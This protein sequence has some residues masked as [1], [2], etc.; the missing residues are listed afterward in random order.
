MIYKLACGASVFIGFGQCAAIICSQLPELK[1]GWHEQNLDWII[2]VT[3]ILSSAAAL[4][5]ISAKQLGSVGEGDIWDYSSVMMKNAVLHG[6]APYLVLNLFLYKALIKNIIHDTEW[7][8]E[9][10]ALACTSCFIGLCT[11]GL[12]IK[13][14]RCVGK[15]IGD[16]KAGVFVL[17]NGICL[18]ISITAPEIAIRFCDFDREL[19]IVVS[20][21]STVLLNVLFT[22][23]AWEYLACNGGRESEVSQQS[24]G[25]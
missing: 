2:Y 9:Y 15:E 3:T 20:I 5:S 17:L 1:K 11:G 12:L 23:V 16:V 19:S 4:L 21:F 24:L 7:W 13:R 25:S 18:A 22:V 6:V 8:Y 10:A 14:L